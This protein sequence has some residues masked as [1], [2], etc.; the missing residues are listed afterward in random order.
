MSCQVVIPSVIQ[1]ACE[2]T[3]RDG[4]RGPGAG[5]D[6]SPPAVKRMYALVFRLL[7]AKV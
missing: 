5:G 1:S 3:C 2:Q 4:D 6:T 7:S